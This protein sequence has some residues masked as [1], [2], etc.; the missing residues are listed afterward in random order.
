[1]EA[2]VSGG[3]GPFRAS[4]TGKV[5]DEYNN[6]QISTHK[7]TVRNES[8]LLVEFGTIDASILGN[9]TYTVSPFVYWDSN[10]ALVLDYAVSP[11]VS[12]GVPSWW[13]E[14]YGS[15]PDLTMNLPWR[16]DQEKGIGS[17]NPQLQKE[18]TR[19]II[20]D[21]LLPEPGETVTISAR[22]QNYSLLDNFTPVRSGFTSM[23]REAA[24]PCCKIKMASVNLNCRESM[25]GKARL[26]ILKVG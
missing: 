20:F 21:P 5:S 14:K 13:E 15:Q 19:D 17:T 16:Y 7:T 3:F 11:D 8:A 1:M 6:E 12:A 25:Q 10:G 18:E 2:N 9:K 4:L 24:E 22:I 26:L 23:T